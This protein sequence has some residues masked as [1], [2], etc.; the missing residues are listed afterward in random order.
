MIDT[1]FDPPRKHG[2]ERPF[3]LFQ[4]IALFAYVLFTLSFG[5]LHAPMLTPS[6]WSYIV[7]ALFATWIPV[8]VVSYIVAAVVPVHDPRVDREPMSA[9]DLARAIVAPQ[10]EYKCHP[11]GQVMPASSKH[12]WACGKCVQGFDHHCR[13][14]NHCVGE[15]NYWHFSLFLG[16]TFCLLTLQCCLGWFLSIETAR[17]FD[18]FHAR[19]ERA[20]DVTSNG[21][22]IAL[23]VF[24]WFIA[25]LQLGVV[26]VLGQL[27]FL[28]IELNIRG[29]TTYDLILIK[30]RASAERKHEREDL[31]LPVQPSPTCHA[32]MVWQRRR[33]LGHAAPPSPEAQRRQ[34]AEMGA[35]KG[36]SASRYHTGAARFS[37]DENDTGEHSPEFGMGYDHHQRHHHRHGV[38][39]DYEPSLSTTTPRS[40]HSSARSGGDAAMRRPTSFR[41]SAPGSVQATPHNP[42]MTAEQLQQLELQQQRLQFDAPV[43]SDDGDDMDSAAAQAREEADMADDG[44]LF[45][46]SCS[47]IGGSARR[48]HMRVSSSGHHYH[49][50]GGGGGG[51]GGPGFTD[52][53]HSPVDNTGGVSSPIPRVYARP[54]GEPRLPH[55]A[56]G[57]I[58]PDSGSSPAPPQQPSASREWE[59]ADEVDA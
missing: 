53:A 49:H 57:A 9:V 5:I 4:Y 8:S 7:T 10:E 36:S 18:S 14:L 34:E 26:I 15:R 51:R 2:F 56:S 41:R 11:C 24:T 43:E 32:L 12:C 25:V 38:E 23:A 39:D 52:L 1:E 47:S 17:D 13:W 40:A 45:G 21:G 19:A 30:R 44:G 59:N 20:F 42:G 50:G 22:S 31:G 55:S 54:S 29:I 16:N 33:E 6:V 3:D 48:H 58:S 35:R 27:F 46:A 28:H 37:P